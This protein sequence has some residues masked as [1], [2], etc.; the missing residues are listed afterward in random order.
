M[1]DVK[2]KQSGT[3]R[4]VTVQIHKNASL[5]F[6]E[7]ETDI[8]GDEMPNQDLHSV[9]SLG[10]L[11]SSEGQEFG[12][13]GHLSYHKSNQNSLLSDGCYSNTGDHAIT[14]EL[15]MSTDQ[16]YNKPCNSEQTQNQTPL[17]HSLSHGQNYST[18]NWVHHQQMVVSHQYNFSPDNECQTGITN[19]LTSFSNV[20]EAS[21]LLPV[22]NT[23]FTRR[24]PEQ[25]S[26]SEST[27]DNSIHRMSAEKLSDEMEI[28]N[29]DMLHSPT[30][31]IDQSIEKLNE[32]ILELDP[33]FDL[34]PVQM[35]SNTSSRN[36]LYYGYSDLPNLSAEEKQKIFQ[37]G[38]QTNTSLASNRK[39]SFGLYDNDG[40]NAARYKWKRSPEESIY[41]SF[42]ASDQVLPK[43]ETCS[44]YQ[45]DVEDVENLFSC[46]KNDIFQHIPGFPVFPDMLYDQQNCSESLQKRDLPSDSCNET[47]SVFFMTE[48]QNSSLQSN[49]DSVNTGGS[50]SESSQVWMENLP[51]L[52]QS[53]EYSL[54]NQSTFPMSSQESVF[55]LN[56]Q[57]KTLTNDFTFW[58][59]II[60]T[61][62]QDGV[63]ADHQKQL[64]SKTIQTS[65]NADRLVNVNNNPELAGMQ[66]SFL[67]HTDV[68]PNLLRSQFSMDSKNSN[69]QGNLILQ[70]TVKSQHSQPPLPEKKRISESELPFGSMSPPSSSF[71]S[72]SGSTVSI[73]FPSFLPDFLKSTE[74]SLKAIAVLKDKEPGCFIV[75]DSHSFRGAYGL[76]M[77]VAT[78]PP[79]VI[80]LNKRVND[81]SN[82]LVRH[83]LIECVQK[84]VR[85]KGCPNE[86]YFGS[87]TALIYQHSITPLAL[88]CKLLI[89]DKDPLEEV[90][91][92]VTK[93]AANSAAELLKQGAACNVW[94]L[95]SVDMESLT[96]YQAVQKALSMTEIQDPPP[97]STV[98]HFKV[99]SHGITLTDNQR[100]LF[101]RRH[102]PVNTIIFC[103]LD[104][105]DRKWQRE[106]LYAKVFGFIAR[107]GNGNENICHLFA[108]HDPEQP[109]SAIVNFV[110]NVMIGSQ[111]KM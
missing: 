43:E 85:L 52:M 6:S 80:H 73:P 55:T 101:F 108:E 79:S 61:S 83:F 99:S 58:M 28:K 13:L 34:I 24:V 70:Q 57:K 89:P 64:M 1:T 90:V 50:K 22:C 102:Y 104:P 21:I 39:V 88:P 100:K 49:T 48:L 97:V 9:D 56:Q 25:I 51:N 12:Y 59:Q 93:T 15:S 36:Q 82:E 30:L 35:V 94:Y 53:N 23:G 74:S 33:T 42:T 76:A 7:R 77:K 19:S 81:I 84:G 111:K 65:C 86:P 60:E 37:Q 26:S 110:S 98:V 16:I 63:L 41:K 4:G 18:L 95:N 3:Y 91:E 106:G 78:P 27:Q 38:M 29:E 10:T 69:N 8:L 44:S 92:T 46:T 72:P 54:K 45:E 40:P 75:R 103:A 71:S 105:Q 66:E 20:P 62:S 17:S 2:N 87:L 109:A 107:K 31:E 96:G 5:R 67:P 11:S 32:L 14:P 68:S 47:S